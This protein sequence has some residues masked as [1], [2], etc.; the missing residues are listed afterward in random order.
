MIKSLLTATFVGIVA[1]QANAQNLRT[2]RDVTKAYQ[3]Q[4]R[5]ISGK[6]GKNYWQNKGRY[7]IAITVMPPNQTV[8]GQEQ[9][10]YF[11][12]SGDTLKALNMKMIMNIHQAGASR[13]RG[14]DTSYIT[15]GVQVDS[16]A[17][18]GTRQSWGDV[19]VSSTNH[20][21]P[22]AAPL[23]PHD[24]VKLNITW[25]YQLAPG[26][27]R[28]GVIDP[29]SFYLAY[30]YPRVSVYDDYNG[31]DKLEFNDRQE[32]YSDFNDYT[33]KVTVP[34]N[35]IVWAT[36]TLQNP[37][38]V[39]RPEYISRLKASM[40]TDSVI[41]IAT[42][43]DL[44]KNN[45]TT[46]NETNTWVWKAGDISDMAV[47]ISNH[48][49]W[50]AASTLVDDAA[51]RRASMQAAYDDKSADFHQAVKFGLHTLN[52]FSH[53]LPGVPYPF[54]KMTA[55]QGFAD[56]EFPMMV[57]DSHT[58]DLADAELL[59][60]HEMAHTWF[61]FY[62]GINETRFGFMDEGWATTFEFFIN[63]TEVG[64]QQ[65]MEVYKN[66][67]VR[68]WIND[69]AGTEDL[70]LITPTSE[71]KD[72]YAHN[73]YGK[74]SLS[75]LA[76]KD[77]LGDDLFKKAL[78]NYMDNWH[79]K[80]PIPWDY[81]N[82][83]NAGAGRDLNW[84]FYNWF[85][86]YN[87]ID[88]GITSVTKIDEGYKIVIDNI[89][90]FAVPFDVKLTYSDGTKGVIHQTPAIWQANQKQATVNL[91]NNK[92]ITSVVIDGGIF[93]DADESNNKWVAK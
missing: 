91:K 68:G 15:A 45:I 50:D 35:F 26:E 58:T 6:P 41:H 37:E 27:G 22:L 3:K 31:W 75:Y 8:K 29:T 54:P 56:M 60:D 72:G 61:P 84:F 7:T 74:A 87:Y 71:L 19:R 2:P 69:P 44:A 86:T 43:A 92:T 38:Q 21:L 81:F 55:F 65:A 79:G 18:N 30:F 20:N 52:W 48:Y 67:R 42:P 90:G 34:K 46:Q 32:F 76:L 1:L 33:L 39:L 14:T 40:L 57:N 28:E 12:N 24:S 59:Q 89:G 5:N 66:W 4:T 93:M 17:V 78:H 10:T 25:H 53:N 88:L 85:Y 70:P 64:K 62:M 47:G 63:A 36:G 13:F 9:I 11:N 80:H 51:Q 49:N 16:V 73:A 82:S 83:I 77:L 23:L